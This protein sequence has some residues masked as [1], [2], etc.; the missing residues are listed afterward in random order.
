MT[1]DK[2]LQD[3]VEFLGAKKP[4]VQQ[5][6]VDIVSGL[7]GSPEGINRLKGVQAALLGALLRIVGTP[8]ADP[9]VSKAALAA[10]VNLS[11]DAA[12]GKVLLQLNTVGRV[13]EFVR[14]KSC[15]HINLLVGCTPLARLAA[16]MCCALCVAC[17]QAKAVHAAAS[18]AGAP[19]V[20]ACIGCAA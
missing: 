1:V 12:L 9:A 14:E 5:A 20:A 11:Q 19:T 13:M 16:Q 7:S 3:L 18:E 4:E 17:L 15:P 2:D 8:D 10:L 6:A